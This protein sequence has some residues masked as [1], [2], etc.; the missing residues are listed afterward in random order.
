MQCIHDNG[1]EFTGEQFQL[2]LQ[3]NRIKDVPT[4]IKN[5]QA[6]AVCEQ[7]HQPIANPL[8]SLI[9]TNPPNNMEEANTIHTALRLSSGSFVFPRDMLLDT[10]NSFNSKKMEII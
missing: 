10:S 6:N 8:R 1:G 5:P 9:Y 7:M 4:T 2:R 3:T